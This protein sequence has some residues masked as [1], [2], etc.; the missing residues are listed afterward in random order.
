MRLRPAPERRASILLIVLAMCALVGAPAAAEPVRLQPTA[1]SH[2]GIA[3]FPRIVGGASAAARARIDAAL[4]KADQQPGC[5]DPGGDW[6]RDVSI[7]MRGPN[8]V[9]LLAADDYD[10]GGAYPDTDAVALVFDLNSGAPINWS[11]VASPALI[12]QG[13]VSDDQP[14]EAQ[15]AALWNFYAKAATAQDPKDCADVFSNAP[16]TGL[17]L[18]PDAKADGLSL[19]A[20]DFPHVVKACGPVVTISTAQLKKLGFKASF[21]AAIDEA[22]RAA[23]WG[24]SSR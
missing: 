9:S 19:M 20:A 22:H 1:P 12:Q 18:W 24:A 7:A 14:I 4:A 23:W 2:P 21:I 17:T 10:C 8:Y 11:A 6:S 5:E 3:S 15:S 16:G 13:A